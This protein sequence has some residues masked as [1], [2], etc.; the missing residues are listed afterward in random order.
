LDLEPI[1]TFVNCVK[2]FQQVGKLFVALICKFLHELVKGG[3]CDLII[4][5]GLEFP[6]LWSS[7][8][9]SW[10]QI[11]RSEFDSRRYHVF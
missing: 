4:K 11:Q 10:L 3:F 5:V 7:G 6:P 9:S 1:T 2:L 8:Q